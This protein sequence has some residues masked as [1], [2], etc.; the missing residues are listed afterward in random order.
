MEPTAFEEAALNAAA[1]VH[2]GLA[3]TATT[4]RASRD[5]AERLVLEDLDRIAT[6]LLGRWAI[7]VD[8]RLDFEPIAPA[9]SLAVLANAARFAE[10]TLTAASEVESEE[11]DPEATKYV[12]GFGQ[13]VDR[14]NRY[15]GQS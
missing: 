1:V 11:W 3:A 15:A 6:D 12:A 4:W 14:L 9:A 2:S 8:E 13:Y 10:Q 7:V 5:P